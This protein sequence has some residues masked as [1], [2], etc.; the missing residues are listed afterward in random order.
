MGTVD[1]LSA[2]LTLM[3]TLPVSGR[4][5]DAATWAFVETPYGFFVRHVFRV[6]NDGARADAEAVPVPVRVTEGLCYVL[7]QHVGFYLLQQPFF[8]GQIQHTGINRQ[9]DIRHTAFTTRNIGTQT[10]QQVAR[11]SGADANFNPGVLC[12]LHK[13]RF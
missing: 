3:K 11:G 10:T 4:S 9:E 12:K 2:S 6:I 8:S 1:H 5:F 7:R 13:R